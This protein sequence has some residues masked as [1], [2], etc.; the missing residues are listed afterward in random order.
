MIRFDYSSDGNLLNV[1]L[2]DGPSIET[3]EIDDSVYVDVD[4]DG[5]PIGI[6]FVNAADFLPFLARH[7][8]HL[9]LPERMR[10]EA[11]LTAAP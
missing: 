4:A 5:R 11:A 6:E 9:S 1:A 2:G 10:G 8:G 3:I 7:G